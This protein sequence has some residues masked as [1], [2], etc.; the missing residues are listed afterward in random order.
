M[1]FSL[2]LASQSRIRTALLTQVGIDHQIIPARVD[3]EAVKQALVA[4]QASARTIADTLAELKARKVAEKNPERVVLGCDQTLCLKARMFSKPE[5]QADAVA[6]LKSLQ[7]QTH[8][9][10]SAIVLYENARPV[11]RHVAEAQMTMRPLSDQFIANYTSQHWPDIAH[12]VGAYM[13]ESTGL[14]LF[15]VISGEYSGIL[16]LPVPP[17]VSYLALRGFIPS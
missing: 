16:G 7:G 9:L 15:S 5:T 3:E 13:I 6:Q 17:L 11:W 14:G 4:E 12:S 2:V 1:A 10:F 8:Q